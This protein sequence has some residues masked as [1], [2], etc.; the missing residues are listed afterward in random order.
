MSR[1]LRA[2]H[3]ITLPRA[4]SVA[5]GLCALRPGD[6]TFAHLRR[7]LDGVVSVTDGEI[8]ATAR[9]L[10]LREQLVVEPS[11]A[12]ASAAIRSGRLKLP[13]G[14]VVVLLSGG[15]AD[16]RGILDSKEADGE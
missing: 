2:G 11:G 10:L 12:A 15:N 3:P 4:D 7:Y 16:I 14:P 5:D 13:A 1:S 6:L 8:L 9:E